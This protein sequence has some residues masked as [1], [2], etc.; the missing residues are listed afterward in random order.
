MDG[1]HSDTCNSESAGSAEGGEGKLSAKPAYR[2]D[3]IVSFCNGRKSSRTVFDRQIVSSACTVV[4]WCDRDRLAINPR[5]THPLG[6]IYH[7]DG[8]LASL[9]DLVRAIVDGNVQAVLVGPVVIWF[10]CHYGRR[11]R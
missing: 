4:A 3:P 7:G 9:G 6:R 10:T 8:R 5:D 11:D 1:A 2:C